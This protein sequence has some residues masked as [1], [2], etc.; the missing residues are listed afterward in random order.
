MNL[1]KSLTGNIQFLSSSQSYRQT[2]FNRLVNSTVTSPENTPRSEMATL[3]KEQQLQQMQQ[4][5][6]QLQLQQQQQ[7]QQHQLQ[8]QQQMQQHQLQLQQQQSHHLQM[9]NS[10]M[11][12]PLRTLREEE[13]E[14]EQLEDSQSEVDQL[15]EIQQR[16]PLKV[17]KV[18]SEMKYVEANLKDQPKNRESKSDHEFANERD[19][20]YYARIGFQALTSFFPSSSLILH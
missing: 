2:H 7:M 3:R 16:K 19:V 13:E 1:G 14:T 8:Q 4:Q 17:R 11:E 15:P 10:P 18:R 5:Q 9:Q 6:L 12:Q 20:Y